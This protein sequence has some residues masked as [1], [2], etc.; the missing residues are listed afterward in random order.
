MSVFRSQAKLLSCSV[1]LFTGLR[2]EIS[3][4][5]ADL[6]KLV[7]HHLHVS[8]AISPRSSSK[9]G[10]HPLAIF[11]DVLEDYV[12]VVTI[13]LTDEIGK[14]FMFSPEVRSIITKFSLIFAEP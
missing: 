9:L 4:V 14:L 6:R 1:I 2:V 11:R 3:R 5:V 12:V 10:H 7:K 8:V 13:L